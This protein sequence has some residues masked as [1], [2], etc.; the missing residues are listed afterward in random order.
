MVG[1]LVVCELVRAAEFAIVLLLLLLLLPMVMVMVMI[2]PLCGTHPA[3]SL[4]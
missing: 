4:A 3:S 1:V 2:S